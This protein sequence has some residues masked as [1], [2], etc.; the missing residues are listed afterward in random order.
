MNASAKE[1]A[2]G[3][4]GVCPHLALEVTEENGV[5][6]H[7][8]VHLLNPQLLV[9]SQEGESRLGLL[10]VHHLAVPQGERQQVLPTGVGLEPIVGRRKLV[11]PRFERVTQMILTL[12]RYREKLVILWPL[13]HLL[14]CEERK[15]L[16]HWDS[17]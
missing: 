4:R 17:I 8:Q 2:A 1:S 12:T 9:L 14:R 6:S 15:V 7:V 3:S 10:R 16:S 5:G 11:A 13:C